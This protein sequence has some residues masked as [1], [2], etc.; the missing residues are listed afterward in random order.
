V[1]EELVVSTSMVELVQDRGRVHSLE[2][3]ASSIF[4]GLHALEDQSP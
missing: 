1:G 4:D 3:Q 2:E